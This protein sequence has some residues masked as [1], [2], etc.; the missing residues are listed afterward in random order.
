M[1]ADSGAAGAG[2]ASG[3]GSPDPLRAIDWGTQLGAG[4]IDVYF[5]PRG[6]VVDGYGSRGWTE[7]ETRQ[8]LAALDRI[9]DVVDLTFRETAVQEGAEFRLTT[10]RLDGATAWMNPPGEWFAGLAAFDPTEARRGDPESDGVLEPG[11]FGFMLL[12]HEFGH[13]LG[14]AHPHDDGGSSTIWDGVRD[15]FGDY[16]RAQLNQ[17]VYSVMS[18]NDGWPAGPPGPPAD[19][20]YGFEASMMALDIAVL[21]AKYGANA[22]HA[23][24]DDV[25]RLPDA[26]G[27]G[28]SYDCIWDAGGY[29]TIAAAGARDAVVN[30]RAASLLGEPGGGGWVSY[31]TRV[32]GGL[33]I[34]NG[35]RIEAA[36]GGRG[37]DV[38]H[39]NVAANA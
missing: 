2:G 39:G 14:L 32:G 35:V 21:Q 5:A 28:A 23:T 16:G 9:A 22:G 30:L 8:A 25:Y 38:L 26:N 10:N 31:A 24:G 7:Y 13:G 29:D 36:R 20:L 27:R 37:D 15:A 34:A 12:L 33:T 6:A 3:V 18:Y 11:S 4:Q 17:G 19:D 1:G